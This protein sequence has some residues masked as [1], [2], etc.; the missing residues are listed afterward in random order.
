MT[1]LCLPML[2]NYLKNSDYGQIWLDIE[3]SKDLSTVYIK[4]GFFFNR[5]VS[6]GGVVT[7]KISSSLTKC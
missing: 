7:L 1:M 3:V 4:S 5:V 2:V 6:I